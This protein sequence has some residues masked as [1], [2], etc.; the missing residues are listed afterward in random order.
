V[1]TRAAKELLQGK[2]DSFTDAQVAVEA[3]HNICSGLSDSFCVSSVQ[4][5][6]ATLGWD[7]E[8][9]EHFKDWVSRAEMYL[10]HVQ[11][12][13]SPNSPIER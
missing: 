13:S 8:R 5:A 6:L 9:L 11:P 2:V 7:N 12:E 3:E 4:H 1:A 10:S